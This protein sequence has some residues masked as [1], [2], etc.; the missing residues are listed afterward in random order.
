MMF[1]FEPVPLT[2]KSSPMKCTV[3]SMLTEDIRCNRREWC[4]YFPWLAWT[5]RKR[6]SDSLLFISPRS[7]SYTSHNSPLH[8]CVLSSSY[9]PFSPFPVSPCSLTEHWR[10]YKASIFIHVSE[11]HPVSLLLGNT[12]VS[13]RSFRLADHSCTRGSC[14]LRL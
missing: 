1:F 13:S 3:S 10:K 11:R 9:S 2:V 14:L 6:H 4:L 5:C 12:G 8:A 7:F